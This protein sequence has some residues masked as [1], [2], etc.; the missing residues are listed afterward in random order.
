MTKM[1]FV[2][3]ALVAAAAY[4]AEPSD[5]RNNAAPR[6]GQPKM[7]TNAP[8][9]C[10]RAPNVGAFATAPYSMPPCMPGAAN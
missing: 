4:A 6:H 2:A 10:E 7:T 5:A 3:A 1:T 8:A 9:D